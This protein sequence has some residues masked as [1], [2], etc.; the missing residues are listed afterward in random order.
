MRTDRPGPPVYGWRVMEVAGLFAVVAGVLAVGGI[1]KLADPTSTVEMF[2]VLGLPRSRVLARVG[3]VVELVVGVT[4][5]LVGGIVLETLVSVLFLIF[6]VMTGALVVRGGSS[7]CGCFGRLSSAPSRVHVAVNLVAAGLA[8]VA[9]VADAPG[10]LD[11]RDELPA[12]AVPYL[13]FV[14]LGTWLGVVALT[15]LPDTVVATR[16]GP[17]TATAV[18]FEVRSVR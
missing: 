14:G 13:F 12:A 16:R 15:V 18:D 10:F 3:G 4:A 8:A 6:A 2:G 5:F 1:F 11:L 17:A 9:V 7:S